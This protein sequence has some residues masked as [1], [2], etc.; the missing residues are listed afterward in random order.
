MIKPIVATIP[1]PLTPS[2]SLYRRP[3]PAPPAAM[4]TGS[5]GLGPTLHS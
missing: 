3:L 5:S 1:P 2:Q 4:P